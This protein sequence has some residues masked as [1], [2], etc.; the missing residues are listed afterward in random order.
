V[1]TIREIENHGVVSS[2]ILADDFPDQGPWEWTKQALN[3]LEEA[4]ETYMVE[5]IAAA[6]F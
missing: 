1:R 2:G 5:V 3:T 6:S 4:T